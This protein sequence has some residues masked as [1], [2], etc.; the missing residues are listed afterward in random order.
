MSWSYVPP[1]G[2]CIGLASARLISVFMP[3]QIEC[4][5]C[6][7]TLQVADEMAGKQGKCIHCGHG[8]TVPGRASPSVGSGSFA[9][10][11]RSYARIHGPRIVPPPA[12]VRCCS[13]FQPPDGSYDLTNVPDA[14]LK[15]IATEDINQARF[16]QLVA[17]FA[18]ATARARKAQPRG[19][20]R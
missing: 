4:P 1:N 5:G 6:K 8:S 7:A 9:H 20:S 14:D 15:C 13:S 11:F 10:A 18:N 17:S 2:D 12:K 3:I 16:A 19:Q